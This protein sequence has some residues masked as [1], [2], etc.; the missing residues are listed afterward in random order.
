MARSPVYGFAGG[1]VDLIPHQFAIAAEVSSRR[2]PRVLLA[3]ET[4]LGKTIEA[5]LILHRLTT[6]GR[7]HRILTIVPDALVVQW[8][9]ELARRFNLRC[10]IFDDAFMAAQRPPAAGDNP[11]FEEPLGLCGFS[12][13]TTASPVLRSRLT[14]AGWDMVV[15]DE[16]HHNPAGGSVV[17]AD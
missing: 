4:G 5:G 9:V 10:R 12:F 8:F 1:R 11:F 7:I 14:D 13:L 17:P 6:I 3:D 16:A 15:V 2:R